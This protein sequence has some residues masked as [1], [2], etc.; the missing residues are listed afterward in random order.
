MTQAL[1]PM[2]SC[3]NLH[4]QIQGQTIIQDLSLN[5]AA[6]QVYCIVGPS[7]SGK[8]S[9]LRLIAGLDT[10]QSGT[11]TIDR[12]LMTDGPRGLPPEQRRLNMVF[13]D[14]ALWPHMTV[15][16]IVGYGLNRWPAVQRDAR[17]AEMLALMQISQYANRRPAQL[18]GGQAQRVAIARALATDPQLLLFDEPLSNLDV[19]LRAQMRKEFSQLFSRL[20]K[21]VVYVT[22]DPLE[23]CAFADR[24]VVMRAGKIEQIA[25]PATLFKSPQSPW[26]ASLAG[27]DS[28]L[29]A[30]L[31]S[32]IDS[33]YAQVAIG[34]RHFRARVGKVQ[35]ARPGQK[36]RLL[37]T[38][39]SIRHEATAAQGL[40]ARVVSS[41]FEGRHWRLDVTAAENEIPFSIIHPSSLPGD[42]PLSLVI[43]GEDC[44]IFDLETARS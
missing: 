30:R 33:Q 6:G 9:L 13:Q 20:K 43:Q 15:R 10:P 17:V 11:I 4:W 40:A 18:S 12:Q 8:S 34:E 21:T 5:L 19:Q 14:Y 1:P 31:I 41:L 25:S 29:E 16:E 44:L 39:G 23:A 2:L 22:H 3:Q 26:I 38:P 35:Y 28:Q 24:I 27:F 7:G 42:S 37:F 36:I 32:R